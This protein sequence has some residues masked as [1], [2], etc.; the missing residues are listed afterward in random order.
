MK[1]LLDTIDLKVISKYYRMGILYGVTTNPT[2]AK[3]FGMAS[4]VEMVKKIR[5]VMPKGEI[6]VEAFGHTAEEIVD[7]A[8][9][10]DRET[11][12]SNLVYKI[13]FS[14]G[15]VAAVSVLKERKFKT[16]LHLIFSTNQALVSSCVGS[17]YICPLVGR[18]DD[19]GHDAF[20]NL[21]IM[22]KG[23]NVSNSDTKIMVSSVR[24]PQH[25]QNA[26]LLGADVVTIPPSIL[27]KMFNHPM[28]SLGYDAFHQDMKMM[29]IIQDADINRNSLVSCDMS[30]KDCVSYMTEI[31]INIIVTNFEGNV[32]IYTMGDFKRFLVQ[33]DYKIQSFLEKPISD[34]VNFDAITIESKSSY[35][36]VRRIF[37]KIEIN[38]LVVIENNLAI[39]GLDKTCLH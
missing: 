3:R 31:K 13:P 6:H 28:T 33:E 30:L 36:D 25:V 4:D 22:K 11:R 8:T 38:H 9:R 21:Q 1:I 19:I 24:H 7:N 39:G 12:D 29:Q 34:F 35:G 10:I 14:E 27:S 20:D 32:G 18:L 26:F 5:E 15:G 16:N 2:L 17:D 37:E 23:L